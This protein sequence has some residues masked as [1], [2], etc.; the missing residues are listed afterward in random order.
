[1]SSRDEQKHTDIDYWNGNG[2]QKL[3]PE[4][5][6]RLCFAND[7]FIVRTA[8]VASGD[9]NKLVIPRV[10]RFGE[11]SNCE[12]FREVMLLRWH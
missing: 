6:T 2:Q 5:G 4:L 3:S 7:L 10:F 9:A 1:M 12:S 11:E 8:P